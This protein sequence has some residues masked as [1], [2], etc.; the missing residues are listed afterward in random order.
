MRRKRGRWRKGRAGGQRAAGGT[1]SWGGRTHHIPAGIRGHPR[2]GAGL[3]PGGGAVRSASCRGAG[4]AGRRGDGGAYGGAA[5]G[6]AAE[7][8]EE[9]GEGFRGRGAAEPVPGGA[10]LGQGVKAGKRRGAGTVTEDREPGLGRVEPVPVPV[11]LTPLLQAR[12]RRL[13]HSA[14]F[15]AP[16]GAV[17]QGTT[18]APSR[19]VSHPAEL[20]QDTAVLCR[21]TLLPYHTRTY[22]SALCWAVPCSITCCAVPCSYCT[23]PSHAVPH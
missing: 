17:R 22:H 19:V 18:A 2:C 12:S 11:L 14:S 13:H 10:G 7:R 8:E 15:W 3:C 20:C 16:Q 4:S 9:I 21:P 23:T 6:A 1:G 5:R